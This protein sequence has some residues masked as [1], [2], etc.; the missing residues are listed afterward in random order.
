MS[1][2]KT[3]YSSNNLALADTSTA[4]RAAFSSLWALGAMLTG[5]QSG[6]N[7]AE[8]ARPSGCYWTLVGSSNSVSAGIDSTDRLHFAGAFTA[9][10]WVRNSAGSAHTWFV[11]QSPSGM[12]DGPWYLCVDYIGP[13]NDQTCTFVVSKQVFSGGSTTARPT[14]TNESPVTS[15]QFCTT[16]ANAGKAHL[17]TD[18]NGSFRWE[19]SRNGTG[20]FDFMIGVESMVETHSGDNARSIMWGQFL[21]SG[22]G[23]LTSQ[24]TPFIRGNSGDGTTVLSASNAQIMDLVGRPGGSSLIS[25]NTTNAIDSTV[26]AFPAEY[27]VEFT[28]SHK[29]GRGRLPDLWEV[30]AQV[31]VGSTFPGTGNPER[32]LIGSRMSASSVA[33]SL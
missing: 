28:A 24:Q 11:L 20:Y 18:A 6:T 10:D 23:A 4:S 29:G 1:L 5:N 32:M 16:T 2:S 8:G 30:G 13:T 15:Q 26:D 21:D 7:G 22:T 31:A 9:A 19:R 27:I 14:S 33:P 17:Q 25:L 3:W 12:L